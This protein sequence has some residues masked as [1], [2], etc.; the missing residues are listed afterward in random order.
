MHK[1]CI[2]I[3]RLL[4]SKVPDERVFRSTAGKLVSDADERTCVPLV[5]R[6]HLNSFLEADLL[7][8]KFLHSASERIVGSDLEN[9]SVAGAFL[10]GGMLSGSN[11]DMP[12]ASELEADMNKSGGV[13]VERRLRSLARSSWF[14]AQRKRNCIDTRMHCG[15]IVQT[16]HASCGGRSGLCGHVLPLVNAEEDKDGRNHSTSEENDDKL[17]TIPSTERVSCGITSCIGFIDSHHL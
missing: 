6:R 15:A 10:N 13:L 16:L 12:T 3:C 1:A 5:K 14:V 17:E 11:N 8:K 2:G 7:I 9:A 4:G